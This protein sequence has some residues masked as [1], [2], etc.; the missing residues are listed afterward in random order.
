MEI[1]KEKTFFTKKINVTLIALFCMVLWGTAAPVIKLGFDLFK[2]EQLEVYSKIL[3]AGLRFVI[4]GTIVVIIFSLR[5]KHLLIPNKKSI[6]DIITIGLV[7][8]TLQFILFYIG[9]AYTTGLKASIFSALTTFFAVGIA[10][11]FYKD[12]KLNLKKSLGC[13]IGFSGILILSLGGNQSDSAGFSLIGDGLVILSMVACAVAT[14]MCKEASKRG[15]IITTTGYSLLFGG[16]ILVIIGI[17]GGG[18]L[19]NVST[20]GI[21]TVFYLG[22]LT[23]IALTL[24]NL[25]LKYNN[26]SLINMYNFLVPVFGTIF[27]AMFLGENV[28]TLRNILSLIFACMGILIVN[29]PDKAKNKNGN[30]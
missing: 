19:E 30:I 20:S 24:Y 1:L 10:H 29:L 22:F 5:E 23:A 4:G 9:L 25:L 13:I 12:D 3:F 11:F 14:V 16:I 18:I 7:Q 21:F 2:I 8:T 28:F 27:S 17:A 15:N 26:V 6:I